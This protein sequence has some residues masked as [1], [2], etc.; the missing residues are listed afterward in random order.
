LARLRAAAAIAT[1]PVI[2]VLDMLALHNAA[3]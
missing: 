3:R 1:G 2:D